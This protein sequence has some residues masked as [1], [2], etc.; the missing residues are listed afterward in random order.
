VVALRTLLAL[1]LAS[2]AAACA[3]TRPGEPAAPAFAPAGPGETAYALRVG[4]VLTCDAH[5]AV[6]DRG[7]ILVR[8]GKIAYVG[9]PVDVPAGFVVIDMPRAW[10][11]PGF[12]D[13][14]S[15]VVGPGG[16]INDMVYPVN[17]DLSTRPTI[18]PA[19]DQMRVAD[20]AGVT[21]VFL[22]PGSGTSISG[23]GVLFKTKTDAGYEESVLR[24]PGGMKSA[25]NYNPQ[26]GAGD[27]GATWAGLQWLTRDANDKAVAAREQGRD[28]WE[29]AN[30]VRVHAG[31]L[32]V[33]VHCA[34]A[35]GVAGVARIWKKEYGTN[36]IMSH[37]SWDGWRAGP[38][39]AELGVPANH[40]PR[41][42]NF[43]SMV[44][45]ERI[46][47]GAAEYIAAGVPLFSL[48]T[49]APVVPQQELFLQGTMSARLGA[50]QVQMLRALTTH[51]AQSILA[52]D[53]VGSLEVGKDADIV[54]ST[55]DPLDPRSAVEL[56]LIDGEIQ[57][58]RQDDGQWF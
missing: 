8:S 25:Y 57:Y 28:D 55:G 49:D 48:N 40:G 32:P 13:L 44:R 37:G 42:M 20:A 36:V 43:N 39:L 15:H 9:K 34:S 38:Y 52:G 17:S 50:D 58:S 6:I 21:T 41:T 18:T 10:A 51:P 35:E 56:V 19:N 2:F 5:D 31:E 12:V 45:E 33:L 47:G 4:K 54:L 30:L 26:R 7:L 27:V 46:V 11:A 23:F 24:D 29:L 1:G 3:S 14:H 16:D 53:R 22:I